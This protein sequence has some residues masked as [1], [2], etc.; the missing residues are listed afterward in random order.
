MGEQRLL[1]EKSK[2]VTILS[3]DYVGYAQEILTCIVAVIVIALCI[4][5]RAQ[6]TLLLTG[7]TR[8]H[9]SCA[10]TCWWV[11]CKCCGLCYCEWTRFA[12]YCCCVK[13]WRGRNLVRMLGQSVGVVSRTVELKNI[14][15]G[16]LP[17]DGTRGNFYLSV[18][19][20]NNP[21]IIT[22]LQEEKLPKC[23]HFPEILTLKIK[24]FML[25]PRVKIVVKALNVVGSQELCD[26][27]LDVDSVMDWAYPNEMEDC[28]CDCFRRSSPS[29]GVN[30]GSV[31]RLNM[32]PLDNDI[33]RA[34]PP[35]ILVEF[36]E[37]ED[38]RQLQQMSMDFSLTTGFQPE[39]KTWL[40]TTYATALKTNPK[41][42]EA[43]MVE[44]PGGTEKWLTEPRQVTAVSVET[45]K[46]GYRLVD[47][48]GNEVQEPDQS[49]LFK[50]TMLRCAW[51]GVIWVWQV[52]TILAFLFAIFMRMWIRS[53]W[54]N[55]YDL[56][57]VDLKG[58]VSFPVP[59]HVVHTIMKACDDAWKGRDDYD[60]NIGK[61]YCL[62]SNEQVL[63][64]CKAIEDGTL[65]A[66]DHYAFVR[67]IKSLT[68]FKPDVTWFKCG[69]WCCLWQDWWV[70]L[71]IGPIKNMDWAIPWALI[72][73]AI[74]I[75]L[76]R[77]CAN[78]SIKSA[79]RAAAREAVASRRATRT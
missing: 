17:Y 27:F 31:K 77:C 36:Y 49:Q 13:R 74:S 44:G 64:R 52:L 11:C 18:E 79:K 22:S 69:E 5:F 26:L 66:K 32:R 15:V 10:D 2:L 7:D 25:E 9:L 54:F 37:Q 70:N 3:T 48:A 38:V 8:I 19:C 76:C 6:V 73:I 28:D 29:D 72:L 35:W 39:I 45:F 51:N 42:L 21:P 40:P 1:E 61:T 41:S 56:T 33:A 30:Y 58:D 71:Q 24:N 46:H 63:A 4:R 67:Y 20:S 68:G 55:N 43:T 60:E 16:D 57:M 50:I 34:T 12:S 14:V 62:P 65:N 59:D 53:C 78:Q 75:C 47:D 23:I